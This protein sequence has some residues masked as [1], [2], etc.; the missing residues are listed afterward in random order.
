VEIQLWIV[1][2]IDGE[3]RWIE[4]RTKIFYDNDGQPVRVAGVSIEAAES[5]QKF[6]AE[7]E[8]RKKA[9]EQ[10]RLS[11]L[12][13]DTALNSMRQ[14]LA[15]YD[16]DTRLVLC[17]QRFQNMY[18]L[19]PETTK[20]GCTLRDLLFQRKAVGTFSGDPDQY[21]AE[22]VDHRGV[23]TKVVELPDGR[24]IWVKSSPAPN[25][26]WVSTHDDVTEQMRL[27]QERDRS[28]K[29]LNTIVENVPIPIF[30]KEAS[31][32]RYVLVNRAGEKFC[33]ISR[34]EIIGKR[35]MISSRRR[36]PI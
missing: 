18:G 29:F 30:V 21:I 35:Y 28:Q 36:K 13:L 11:N 25:G 5:R 6:E 34:A 1:R 9:E 12:R 20:P 23:K 3:M 24:M 10:L 7:Y 26:G 17:N 4:I 2:P 22:L 8:A 19:S 33:G 27:K 31:E 32:L 14:G 16:S 15:L